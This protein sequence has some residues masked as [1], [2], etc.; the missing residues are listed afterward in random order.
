MLHSVFQDIVS[1]TD[2][3]D[4]LYAV[5]LNEKISSYTPSNF[6]LRTRGSSVSEI[7]IVGWVFACIG[8][9]VNRVTVDFESDINNELS[10]MKQGIS[11]R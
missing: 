2:S 4:H 10:C 3:V 9:G 8:S 6:G 7:L 11:V 5:I 1:F